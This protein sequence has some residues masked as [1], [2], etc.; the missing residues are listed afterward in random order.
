MVGVATNGLYPDSSSPE[1]K[2]TGECRLRLTARLGV[3]EDD[4][5]VIDARETESLKVHLER[6]S[7]RMLQPVDAA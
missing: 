4:H 6:A 5:R 7:G 2:Q 1:A 3:I